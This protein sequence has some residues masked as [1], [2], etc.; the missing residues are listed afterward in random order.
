MAY[1][2]KTL[3]SELSKFIRKNPKAKEIK[4]TFVCELKVK[5]GTKRLNFNSDFQPQQ[6]PA[7]RKAKHKCIYHKLSDLSIDRK[8][9]DSFQ[10]CAS[11]AFVGVT[12]YTPRKKRY[13]YLIDI[14]D[15]DFMINNKVKSLTE[16]EADN[17]AKHKLDLTTK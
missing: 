5:K 13:L 15:I 10:T 16:E 12:W 2:E 7:L 11:P 8:P 14:D 4:F 1:S 3:T 6:L 9:F 17:V